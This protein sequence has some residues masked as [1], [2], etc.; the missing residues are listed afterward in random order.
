[1]RDIK[2]KIR[3]YDRDHRSPEAKFLKWGVVGVACTTIS[4]TDD[5]VV[6][7]EDG[8]DEWDYWAVD[9]ENIRQYTGLTD[10]KM[11]EVYDGDI[12]RFTVD[13]EEK[14][15]R[16]GYYGGKWL[17]YMH[18]PDEHHWFD[19]Y[20]LTDIFEGKYFTSTEGHPF[21]VIGNVFEN[22]ELLK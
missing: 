19:G 2:F 12:G 11:V 8:G 6:Y 15:G 4:N 18:P 1:M 16:V 5:L 20:T 17:V 7:N 13:G 22:P 9:F 14:I 3:I 10:K 21:E